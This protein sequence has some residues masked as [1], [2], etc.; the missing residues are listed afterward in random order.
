MARR[1][2]GE[3]PGCVGQEEQAEVRGRA[4]GV[5]VEGRNGGGG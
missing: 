1:A 4:S 5:V 2:T 3:G